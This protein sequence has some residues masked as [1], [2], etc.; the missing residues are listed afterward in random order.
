[1]DLKEF[2]SELSF[3][4]KLVRLVWGIV[5]VLLFRPSPRVCHG[6]RRQLLRLFGAKIGQGVR[7]YNSV[8]VYYPA[9]LILE[10]HV[11]IGPHVDLYCVATIKVRKNSM[12]S[13]YSYLCT[14]TH[15]YHQEHLPLVAMPITVGESTW[16]CAR[17]FIG[18]GITLGDQVVVA[19][20]SVVVKDVPDNSVVGGNPCRFIKHRDPP[21]LT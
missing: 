18:P 12:I 14:G 11:V 6:W 8:S 7:V 20:C 15:D 4:N 19:A 1:M 17:A 9:N 5:W 13:Q 16:V 10:D 21:E 3:Q 2:K